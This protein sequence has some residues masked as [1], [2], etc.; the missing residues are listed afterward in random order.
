MAGQY[1]NWIQEIQHDLRN[2]HEKVESQMNALNSSMHRLERDADNCWENP[3]ADERFMVFQDKMIANEKAQNE[4]IPLIEQIESMEKTIREML[5]SNAYH[6]PVYSDSELLSQRDSSSCQDFSDEIITKICKRAIKTI[7]SW[8]RNFIDFG[9]DYPT[10]FTVFDVLSVELQ[11]KYY[12]ELNPFFRDAIDGALENQYNSLS[13][14]E[15]FILD[16]SE[17]S[18]HNGIDREAVQSK[19]LKKFNEL[20]NE[21]YQLRKIQ[22]FEEKRAW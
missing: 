3:N 17:C 16:Y 15:S 11:S 8:D 4:L 21:H 1:R 10:K 12:E 2:L 19:I 9:E 5:H 13:S 18:D 6:Y 7:N 20:L 22:N 14:V